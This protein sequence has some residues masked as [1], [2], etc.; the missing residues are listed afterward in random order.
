MPQKA[1]PLF[2]RAE[3][4]EAAVQELEK[5]GD[6]KGLAQCY[7]DMGKH[8]DAARA[9]ERSGL[10]GEEAVS[11]IQSYLY[12]HLAT[13]AP[14]D[15]KAVE[16]LYKEATRM[17]EQGALI[18]AL[19]RFRLLGDAKNVQDVC[20]RL[21][22]HEEALR[23]FLI[24][25]K[26]DDA[27]RYVRSPGVT[28]SGDFVESFAQQQ[29]LKR[30]QAGFDERKLIE[31]TFEMLAASVRGMQ[32]A[33]ARPLI[34]RVF[35]QV[36]GSM[37]DEHFLPPAAR[38]ILVAHRVS[39]VIMGMLAFN[40][41]L[42]LPAS[43]TLRGLAD[44]VTRA[45]RETGDPDLAACAAYG[46]GDMKEF[47]RLASA[48]ELTDA[49]AVLLA[50]SRTR[51]PEAV[52]RLMANDWIDQAEAACFRQKDHARAGRYAEERG[53]MG[54]AV[55][56][57]MDGRDYDSALRCAL[58]AGD[59]RA[60]ARAYEHLGRFDD[61]IA[62]WTRLGKTREAERVRKKREKESPWR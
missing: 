48:L 26:V 59:E 2:L 49:N 6:F 40:R 37:I 7:D 56:W 18:P 8:L 47:E 21:G 5:A 19:A 60:A 4:N 62:A 43:D 17:K 32:T 50:E 54:E 23:Y 16:A 46:A 57:Y 44:A 24:A 25:D 42:G 41:Q 35:D 28:V 20:L 1:G 30:A 15:E 12:H 39:N 9:L 3:E 31:V 38:E 29:W 52:A 51:Y 13:T 10:D 11:L 55:R 58:A 45:A 34:E 33:A 61:A 14:N 53:E 27:L 22:R 36:F